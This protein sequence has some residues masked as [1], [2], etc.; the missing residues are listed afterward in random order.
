MTLL[1]EHLIYVEKPSRTIVDKAIDA[2]LKLV[3]EDE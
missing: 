3:P 1:G 2:M